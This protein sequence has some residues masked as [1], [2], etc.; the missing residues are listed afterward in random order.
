MTGEEVLVVWRRR[1]RRR[2]ER[3]SWRALDKMFVS[4]AEKQ[5]PMVERSLYNL[6]HDAI[7]YTARERLR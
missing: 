7:F 2:R 6:N 5:M 3:A 4:D 1:E